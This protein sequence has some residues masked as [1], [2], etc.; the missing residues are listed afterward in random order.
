MNV[1][2]CLSIDMVQINTDQIIK[3]LP[4]EDGGVEGWDFG[5]EKREA[6]IL[7]NSVLGEFI[8]MSM[9]YFWSKNK[10]LFRSETLRLKRK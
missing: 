3:Q 6:I 5:K 2:I 1:N 9:Y 10:E 4:L 8:V 7:Y